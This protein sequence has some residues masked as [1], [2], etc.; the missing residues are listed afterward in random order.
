LDDDAQKRSRGNPVNPNAQPSNLTSIAK[1]L[2]TQSIYK[3]WKNV[4]SMRMKDVENC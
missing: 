3:C 1:K 2:F 4:R